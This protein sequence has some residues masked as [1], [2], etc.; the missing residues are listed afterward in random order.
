LQ[1]PCQLPY[2]EKYFKAFDFYKSWP[3]GATQPTQDTLLLLYALSS[4]VE[5]GP[6]RE[7]KPSTWQSSATHAKWQAWHGLQ[8]MEGNEAMRLFVKTLEEDEVLRPGHPHHNQITLNDSSNF[9][10]VAAG[11]VLI[12][13]EWIRRCA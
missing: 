11:L 5:H 12:L 9:H 3:A 2:P 6:C 1:S 4:Q 10:V 13:C 8:S 7:P